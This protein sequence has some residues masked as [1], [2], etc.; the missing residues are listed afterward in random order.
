MFTIRTKKR[1][2]AKFESIKIAREKLASG[3]FPKSA[4]IQIPLMEEI[5]PN[6]P[7]GMF[8][9]QTKSKVIAVCD[10]VEKARE[11]LFNS[12]KSLCGAYIQYPGFPVSVGSG[13]AK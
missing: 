7:S 9:V 1:I 5:D 4:F 13:S 2:Y 3:N 12:A 10:S 11:A 6:K 8:K